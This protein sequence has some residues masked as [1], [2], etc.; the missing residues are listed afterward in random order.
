MY[1]KTGH[2]DLQF[3]RL[4]GQNSPWHLSGLSSNF[5]G[6]LVSI[7]RPLARAVSLPYFVLFLGGL[8]F[9]ARFF[10][11]Y[12]LPL[13]AFIFLTILLT[14]YGTSMHFLSIYTVFMAFFV[15]ALYHGVLIKYAKRIYWTKTIKIAGMALVFYLFIFAANNHILFFSSLHSNQ[16]WLISASPSINRGVKQLD[17]YL[18][19]VIKD[20]A[21]AT[22]FDQYTHIKRGYPRLRQYL[23][24]RPNPTPQQIIIF[25][26]NFGWFSKL[27]LFDRR[28]FYYNLPIVSMIDY[29]TKI[30]PANGSKLRDLYFVKTTSFG[31]MEGEKFVNHNAEILEKVLKSNSFAPVEIKRR[32]GQVAYLVYHWLA[33]E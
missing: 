29:M 24:S 33:V 28:A 13:C 8:V 30:T 1:T 23:A 11:V 2:F 3:A 6:N 19:K 16:S 26:D 10:K 4:F 12:F 9:C 17:D 5:F 25:D 15:A 31:A 14:F 32:D 22:D 18:E 7:W 20:G 27:W 21:V